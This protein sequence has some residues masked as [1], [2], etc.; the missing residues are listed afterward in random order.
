MNVFVVRIE[1]TARFNR[2]MPRRL[3]ALASSTVVLVAHSSKKAAA[4]NV[5]MGVC[6][7]DREG[8]KVL[9]HSGP[10]KT[11]EV[12]IVVSIPVPVLLTGPQRR[13]KTHA[14]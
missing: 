9:I 13:D 8:A 3:W 14:H 12:T 10:S 1:A 4:E 5:L 2:E 7:E 11:L 6:F